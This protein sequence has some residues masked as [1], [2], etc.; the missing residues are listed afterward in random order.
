MQF[1]IDERHE[2]VNHVGGLYGSPLE[3]AAAH[4]HED[5]VILLSARGA[6]IDLN[7]GQ[8][9]TAI[10]PAATQGKVKI[11]EILLQHKPHIN[12]KG[13]WWEETP[14]A[15]ASKWSNRKASEAIVK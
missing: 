9:G 13:G 10:Q 15:A 3:A 4:G 7:G 1:L 8:F 6:N 5:A 12:L 11:V 14:L 2:D